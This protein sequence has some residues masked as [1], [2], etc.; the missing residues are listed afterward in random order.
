MSHPYTKFE[1]TPLWKA[2]DSAIAEL[3]RNRDVELTTARTHV[4]GYLCEQLAAQG[5]VTESS[6]LRD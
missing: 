3:E 5:T 6:L 2:I 4:I 1:Q